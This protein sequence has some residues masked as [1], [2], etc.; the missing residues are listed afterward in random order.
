MKD[1]TNL[2]WDDAYTAAD[3]SGLAA[4]VVDAMS[5]LMVTPEAQDLAVPVVVSNRSSY[6]G[7]IGDYRHNLTL[8]SQGLYVSSELWHWQKRFPFYVP[9]EGRVDLTPQLIEEWKVSVKDVRSAADKIGA[10]I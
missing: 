1:C 3:R 7:E 10:T 9:S 6:V 4:A 5:R 8:T 2:R